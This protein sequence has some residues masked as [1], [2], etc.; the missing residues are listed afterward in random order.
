[1]QYHRTTPLLR[2]DKT[3]CLDCVQIIC[4]NLCKRD[5]WGAVS[6]AFGLVYD[7][8]T[9]AVASVGCNVEPGNCWA[10]DKWI[11]AGQGVVGGVYIATLNRHRCMCSA[12]SELRGIKVHYQLC[13]GVRLECATD[14]WSAFLWLRG[15]AVS[16]PVWAR[17]T[18]KDEQEWAGVPVVLQQKCLSLI[19]FYNFEAG[20]TNKWRVIVIR[21]LADTNVERTDFFSSTGSLRKLMREL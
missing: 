6:Y 9:W 8:S 7:V 1:M 13:V 18:D 3:N 16:S 5:H 14:V 20:G 11:C 19:C 10:L 15:D 4:Y 21:K 12:Y 17:C 2:Q